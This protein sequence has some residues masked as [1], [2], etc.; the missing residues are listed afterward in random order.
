[1]ERNVVWAPWT[2][3]G[4]EHL[5]LV[6]NNEDILADGVVIG[7][8]EDM[9]FRLR[10]EI[11]C[12]PGWRVREL[13]VLSLVD[14]GKEVRILADGEGQWTTATGD[15]LRSLNGCIDA[16]ISATPFTNTLPIRRLMLDP[17]ESVD[18]KVAYLAVSTLQAEVEPQRYT[19]L[20][21]G[22]EGATYRFESLDGEFTADL[23]VDA[24]GLVLDYPEMFRRI[25]PA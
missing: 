18:L 15:A 16:D 19:C 10:Y 4:L 11:R 3:V 8:E 21:R 6:Q 14:K 1:M 25:V 23:P 13:K 17:G 7:A 22:R 20:K 9:P 12:D 5:K 2:G 24:D